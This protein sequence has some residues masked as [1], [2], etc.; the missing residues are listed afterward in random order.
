ML[1]QGIK[2]F[3]CIRMSQLI[4]LVSSLGLSERVA[5]GVK[6][7]P[8]GPLRNQG[9]ILLRVVTLSGQ[10]SLGL[11]GSHRFT[12]GIELLGFFP[13]YSL[14]QGL[15]LSFLP[16]PELSGIRLRREQCFSSPTIQWP[17]R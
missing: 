10:T 12:L 17:R 13:Q 7:V 14:F 2:I 9:G 3:S 15:P 8:H 5:H 1:S 4:R 11:F 6:P 16:F